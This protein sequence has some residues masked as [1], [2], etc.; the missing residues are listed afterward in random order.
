MLAQAVAR[1]DSDGGTSVSPSCHSTEIDIGY[2]I[3]GI[4]GCL[5]FD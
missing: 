5:V 1:E 4:Y 2:R 3:S